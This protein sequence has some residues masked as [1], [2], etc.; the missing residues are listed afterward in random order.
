[1]ILGIETSCDDTCAAVLD[2]EGTLLSNV[3]TSQDEIHDR[4]QGVVPELAS[5]RH[6][7]NINL[8]LEETLERSDRSFSDLDTV[9]V[10]YGPGLI[11]SLLTGVAAAKSIAARFDLELIP[12]NHIEAHV[13]SIELEHDIPYP[14]VS[15]VAS[16]G[17]TVLFEVRGAR[18]YEVLGHTLD[19]AAG[20]AYDKVAKMLDLGYPGGPRIESTA[21]EGTSKI[22][23]PRPTLRG[24]Q[25][26]SWSLEDFDF[27]FSGIKTAVYYYLRDHEDTKPADVAASFQ[28]AV[29]DVLVFKTLKAAEE[30]SC[31]RIAVGGGV[32][33]NSPLRE[34]F[35]N[36]AAKS[37][38]EVYFP[39]LE[40]CTDN[41]AMVGYRSYSVEKRAGLDLNA[42]PRLS[43]FT[44]KTAQGEAVRE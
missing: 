33:A 24:S 21:Q 38:R 13:Y 37:D 44:N 43:N 28:Q 6:C 3:V 18:D 12:V 16:G 25:R 30:R 40:Y 15:L 20:E 42:Q 22:D 17:H 35:R 1:M 8:V 31:R 26:W 9:A 41:A 23:F 11:G 5:R 34:T 10:T 7:A 2:S 27:S 36:R 29:N 39:S 19:D 32:A 14:Y 4:Y